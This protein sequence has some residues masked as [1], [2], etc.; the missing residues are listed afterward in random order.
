MNNY[1]KKAYEGKYAVGAFVFFDYDDMRG[2]VSAADEMGQSSVILMTSEDI[3]DNLGVKNVAAFVAQ[4]QKGTAVQLILHLDHGKTEEL[5]RSCAEAGYHSIMFDGSHLPYEENITATKRVAD[6][7]HSRGITVEGELGR[8]L[9]KE[10][11]ADSADDKFTD[12]DTVPAFVEATGVDALAVSIGN[13]HGMYK[14]E[15]TIRFDILE[16]IASKSSVPLVLHGGTGIPLD[17]IRRAISMGVAKVNVGTAL[18]FAHL[19]AERKYLQTSD[20]NSKVSITKKSRFIRAAVCNAAKE[21]M[22]SFGTK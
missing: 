1:L 7:C 10:E 19:D 15:P 13:V 6:Y 20:D 11:N 5:V 22:I 16:K 18:K 2:I 14:G 3:A 12:P 9:G 17:Y 21:Y 8:L 4:L